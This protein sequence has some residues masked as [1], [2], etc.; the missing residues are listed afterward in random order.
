MVAEQKQIN[1]QLRAELSKLEVGIQNATRKWSELTNYIN[2][3]LQNGTNRLSNSHSLMV[4]A[5]EIQMQIE[6]LFEKYK[7]MELA[8]KKIRACNNNQSELRGD[9]NS[10]LYDMEHYW[11]KMQ[12]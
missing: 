1:S 2:G 8:N 4:Q 12:P 3:T 5:H 7:Q 11:K 6:D 10:Y 9:M